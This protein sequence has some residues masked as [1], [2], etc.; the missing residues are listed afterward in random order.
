M[1]NNTAANNTLNW[2]VAID[3]NDHTLVGSG[4]SS[5]YG[6]YQYA[7]CCNLTVKNS[8]IIRR[9]KSNKAGVKIEGY[10]V[11]LSDVQLLTN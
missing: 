8:K 7:G 2:G 11:M 10:S 3:L 9:E 5:G 4:V 1:P 6:I